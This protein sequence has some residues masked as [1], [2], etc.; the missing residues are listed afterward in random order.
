[1]NE[2]DKEEYQMKVNGMKDRLRRVAMVVAPLL[3]LGLFGMVIRAV[4]GPGKADGDGDLTPGQAVEAF[5]RMLLAG[6]WEEAAGMTDGEDMEKYI[7]GFRGAW[8]ESRSRDSAVMAA[9][10]RI[11]DSTVIIVNDIDKDRDGKCHVHYT[12]SAVLPGMENLERTA[13]LKKIQTEGEEAETW[14]ITEIRE[15]RAG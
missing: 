14:K 13:G 9:A 1:M 3:V 8:E 11:I 7:A 4:S 2:T 6:R 10:A 15:G 12:I 5:N